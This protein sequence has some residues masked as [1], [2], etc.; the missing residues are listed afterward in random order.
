MNK[1]NFI[2]S[3]IKELSDGTYI[4]LDFDSVHIQILSNDIDKA[5]RD[6]ENL[7]LELK[8][9]KLKKESTWRDEYESRERLNFQSNATDGF[10]GE[11][12][13]IN[14]FNQYKFFE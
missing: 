4:C 1:E 14:N 9:I 13:P 8:T 12:K 2:D 11:E 3:Q 7:V 10:A 6:F 5:I